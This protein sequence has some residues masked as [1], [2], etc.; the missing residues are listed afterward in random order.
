MEQNASILQLFPCVLLLLPLK[1]PLVKLCSV[2]KWICPN[3][4]DQPNSKTLEQNWKI[5]ISD[6][7]SGRCLFFQNLIQQPKHGQKGAI[8][9]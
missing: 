6:D 4:M 1:S 8:R 2:F 7:K 9:P 5:G 3:G